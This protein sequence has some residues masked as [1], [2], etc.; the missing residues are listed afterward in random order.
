MLLPRCL[1]APNKLVALARQIT[2]CG[3]RSSETCEEEETY[4][5]YFK[6]IESNYDKAE[7]N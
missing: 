7:K 1:L 4:V 3:F 2:E 5:A 6:V